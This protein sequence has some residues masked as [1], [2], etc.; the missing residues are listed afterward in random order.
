MPGDDQPPGVILALQR[1]AHGTLRLLAE[2]LANEDLTSSEINALANLADGHVRTVGQL[3]S[4]AGTRPTTLTSVLDRL[5]RRGYVTRELDPAD[6]RS[7]LLHLT[8]DGHPVARSARDA[9]TAIEQEALSDLNA[10]DIAG[11]H[12]VVQALSPAGG[13]RGST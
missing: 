4:A 7:F 6:R 13:S 3:A 5:A 8:A 10:D 9:M 12:R 1:A 11:F 2:R